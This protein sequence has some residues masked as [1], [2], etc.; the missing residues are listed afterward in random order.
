[1]IRVASGPP[2]EP[3]SPLLFLRR[4]L[5]SLFRFRLGLGFGLF[6]R[7][8]W[9][10]LFRSLPGGRLRSG[11]R[12]DLGSSFGRRRRSLFRLFVAE[13][14]FFLFD[15]HRLLSTTQFVL[16]FQPRQLVVVF[17]IVLLEIHS[18]LPRGK[19]SPMRRGGIAVAAGVLS[20][21][22]A[23]AVV[24]VLAECCQA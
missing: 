23:C 17:E 11:F 6:G 4:L 18:I 22:N 3:R 12:G 10:G 1:M 20:R 9:R 16:L 8:L 14:Q 2:A 15:L 5:R 24:I 19:S 7:F 21:S 13:D